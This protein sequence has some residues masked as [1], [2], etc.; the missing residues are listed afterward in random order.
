MKELRILNEIF[1]ADY[2]KYKE[3]Y[4]KVLEQILAEN[5][6]DKDV[7]RIRNGNI[8][9]ILIDNG[10]SCS[11]PYKYNFYTYIKDKSRL[12][13][14]AS[15]WISTPIDNETIRKGLLKEYEPII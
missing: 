7:R 3:N 14:K 2:N 11:H 1:E 10:Y 15:G 4:K 12:S 13:I 9:K 6:L 8:G 5:K